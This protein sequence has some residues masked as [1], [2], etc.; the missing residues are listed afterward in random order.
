MSAEEIA[1]A[2]A[3]VAQ[4]QLAPQICPPVAPPRLQ[5]AHGPAL[6]ALLMPLQIHTLPH[7]NPRALAALRRTCR[8]MAFLA[9]PPPAVSGKL[10]P[11]SCL[12][13]CSSCLLAC[14]LMELQSS[15]FSDVKPPHYATSVACAQFPRISAPSQTCQVE[16]IVRSPGSCQNGAGDPISSLRIAANETRTAR[17]SGHL[18]AFL[19]NCPA[20]AVTST[21]GAW[22]YHPTALSPM[23]VALDVQTAQTTVVKP[24][25]PGFLQLN[26]P[27][28][29]NV[30]HVFDSPNGWYLFVG[31]AEAWA[32]RCTQQ[33][34]L[35]KLGDLAD[36]D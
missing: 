31:M 24:P 16:P 4:P 25:A 17:T 26:A 2:A 23:L 33:L 19:A 20:V 3:A 15:A 32:K 14:I 10:Q 1:A 28:M 22:H 11:F 30:H 27:I 6:D 34:L 29:L 7:L 9:D 8:T 18:A 13:P 36:G 5:K 35:Y 21:A 12:S